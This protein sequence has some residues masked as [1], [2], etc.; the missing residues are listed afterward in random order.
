MNLCEAGNYVFS[1][2]AFNRPQGCVNTCRL[3]VLHIAAPSYFPVCPIC[4]L[5]LSNIRVVNKHRTAACSKRV[6]HRAG[7]L[8]SHHQLCRDETSASTVLCQR[9]YT[10][11]WGIDTKHGNM[12]GKEVKRE[13]VCY[14]VPSLFPIPA[15]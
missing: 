2:F 7:L 8:L 6:S 4:F 3:V 13:T 5:S 14:C 12:Q 10:D 9:P 1:C 15:L 11:I